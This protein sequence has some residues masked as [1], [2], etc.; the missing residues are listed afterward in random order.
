MVITCGGY[1]PSVLLPLRVLVLLLFVTLT[2]V[3]DVAEF[4]ADG[5]V[6]ATVVGLSSRSSQFD[7]ESWLDSDDVVL[8]IG[9]SEVG[10]INAKITLVLDVVLVEDNSLIGVA[11]RDI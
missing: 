9:S 7:S 4:V 2:L 3:L 5:V 10:V 8:K 11:K 6:V 1:L